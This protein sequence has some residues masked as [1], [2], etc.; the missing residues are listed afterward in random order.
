[1][2]NDNTEK[3]TEGRQETAGAPRCSDGIRRAV[4][5]GIPLRGGCLCG[6][7]HRHYCPATVA[8]RLAA[9]ARRVARGAGRPDARAGWG[10]TRGVATADAGTRV[11]ARLGQS[12]GSVKDGADRRVRVA[13][14]GGQLPDSTRA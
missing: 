8:D 4:R 10:G 3:V 9:C 12:R 5:S 14:R 6:R 13:R 1:M 2:L 7:G 11:T